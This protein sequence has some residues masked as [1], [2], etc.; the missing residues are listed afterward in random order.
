VTEFE[1]D[2]ASETAG[3]ASETAGKASFTVGEGSAEGLTSA[4][5]RAGAGAEQGS[6]G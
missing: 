5:D 2:G 6:G 3:A 1:V 4:R